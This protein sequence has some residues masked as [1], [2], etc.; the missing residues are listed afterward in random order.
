MPYQKHLGIL[1]DNKHNFKQ[2]ND[3]TIS[4]VNK[5]LS[6]IKKLGYNLRRK[7]LVTIYRAFLRPLIDYSDITSMASHKMNLF[8]KTQNLCFI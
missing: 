7:S 1:L 3:S 5:D 8:I 2:H 6:I 4:K